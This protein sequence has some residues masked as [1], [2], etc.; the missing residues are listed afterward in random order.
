MN[1]YTLH[2]TRQTIKHCC[3]HTLPHATLRWPRWPQV[4]SMLRGA[5]RYERLGAKM[6]GGVLL[7]GPP[8]TG[9]TLLGEAA[10]VH[11]A[12][13]VRAVQLCMLRSLW[14]LCAPCPAPP[15]SRCWPRRAGR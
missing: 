7:C 14:L 5:G 3:N 15:R 4:V 13:A 2:S 1:A 12:R 9:K 8:G 11:A 6:P 10:A